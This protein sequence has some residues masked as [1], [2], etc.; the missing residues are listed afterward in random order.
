MAACALAQ[1]VEHHN[2]SCNMDIGLRKQSL[3]FKML[4]IFLLFC[5]VS[6]MPAYAAKPAPDTDWRDQALRA[7][8]RH[9]LS[10]AMAVLD[11]GLGVHPQDPSLLYIR[12]TLY[13]QQRQPQKALED[14]NQAIRL[15]GK[16]PHLRHKVAL[17][18]LQL[19]REAFVRGDNPRAVV[20]LQLS[21]SEIPEEF[22]PL[23]AYWLSMALQRQH[24]YKQ[25]SA[26]L[27]TTLEQHPDTML[28][29]VLLRNLNKLE[30]NRKK[31]DW[32]MTLQMGVGYDETVGLYPEPYTSPLWPN[33]KDY[34]GQLDIESYWRFR[35]SETSS[36]T[37]SY[38]LFLGDY[39]KLKEYNTAQQ[40]FAVDHRIE[41]QNGNWG[42]NLQYIDAD[43]GIDGYQN[44]Q[45]ASLYQTVSPTVR[46]MSIKKLSLL[47]NEYSLIT[48]QPYSGDGISGLYRYYFLKSGRNDR[49]YIGTQLH[50]Y[51]AYDPLLTHTALSLDLGYERSYRRMDYG[52]LFSLENRDYFNRTGLNFDQVHKI[53]V[54][55]NM[56]DNLSMELGVSHVEGDSR[57]YMSHYGRAL[58]YLVTRWEP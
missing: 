11:A 32:W 21:I 55:Y 38:R 31:T 25:A 18:R 24:D 46:R 45:V 23:N 9:E 6:F 16:W 10:Q 8:S 52:F 49:T 50:Y 1:T 58:A 15:G 14:L 2:D 43:L 27:S 54:A 51:E 20:L 57:F 29:P 34:L 40:A 12:G 7:I 47:H 26:L 44:N 33:D 3:K 4:S 53:Y 5:S 42:W 19:G 41:T 17:A 13:L 56:L 35:N 36:T 30:R 39:F 37:L 22:Q 28:R 48:N